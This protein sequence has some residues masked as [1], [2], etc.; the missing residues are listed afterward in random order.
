MIFKVTPNEIFFT[1]PTSEELRKAEDK[2]ADLCRERLSTIWKE[3]NTTRQKVSAWLDIEL[4]K[5]RATGTAF[6]FLMLCEIVTYSREKGYPVVA[7]GELSGAVISYLLSITGMIPF[8]YYTPE[9]VWG[10]DANP[11]SPD[12]T[13]GIAPQV[14]PLLQKHLDSCYGFANCNREMFRQ[15]PLVDL[16][17]CAQLGVLLQDIKKYPTVGDIDYIVCCHVAMDILTA[18]AKERGLDIPSIEEFCQ[19]KTWDLHTLSRLYAFTMGGFNDGSNLANLDDPKFFVTREEF[20][21]YL[22]QYN[23]PVNVALEIIKNGVW[24][25]GSKRQKYTASLES[26]QVPEFVINYYSQ[27]CNLWTMASCVDRVLHKCY[28]VLL[29]N[30]LDMDGAN[31]AVHIFHTAT[32]R[33]GE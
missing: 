20:Y 19:S 24:A 11:I 32:N 25:T 10:L 4:E 15:I 5:M 14:R 28:L 23:I 6:H 22:L 30:A 27:V 18:F 12:C 13:I 33:T 2:V 31:S 26:Y 8:E 3:D 21:H 17:I 1:I 9:I 29:R 16:D 7:L